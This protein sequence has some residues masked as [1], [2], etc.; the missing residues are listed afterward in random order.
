MEIIENKIVL[1]VEKRVF[2]K[3]LLQKTIYNKWQIA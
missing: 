3:R 1:N 2:S